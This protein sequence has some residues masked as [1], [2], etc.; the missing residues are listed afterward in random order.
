MFLIRVSA[1]VCVLL[2][3]TAV[4]PGGPVA[5]ETPAPAIRLASSTGVFNLDP[6]RATDRDSLHVIASVYET[7]YQW[8]PGEDFEVKPLLARDMPEFSDDGLTAVIRLRDDA[9]YHANEKVFRDGEPRTANADDVV[10]G[11]TRA[12][13][14]HRTGMG[15]LL[16]GLVQGLDD[17][18]RVRPTIDVHRSEVIGLEAVDEHTVRIRLTRPYR[19]LA[20]LLAHPVCSVVPLEVMD[21]RTG[22]M[23]ARAVGTGPYRL[24]AIAAGELCILTAHENYYGE[25]AAVGRVTISRARYWEEYLAG[26]RQGE[27]AR[28]SIHPNF[29]SEVRDSSGELSASLREA[30]CSMRVAPGHGYYFL[31]F[32]MQ[33]D[34][35][36]AQDDGRALRNA[37]SHSIDRSLITA[38]DK[39][40]AGGSAAQETILPHGAEFTMPDSVGRA[41]G[42]FNRAQANEQLKGTRF[43]GGRNPETGEAL[44]LE[45]MIRGDQWEEPFVQAVREALEAL[46]MELVT[47]TVDSERYMELTRT[48]DSD[49]FISGWF[50]DYPCPLNFLQLFW[51]GN[52]GSSAQFANV[53]RYRSERF[54]RHFSALEALEPTAENRTQR[55]RETSAM[56]RVLTEEKPIV[57]LVR[58][59]ET[60][61]YSGAIKWADMPVQTFNGF[62][63]AQP[64]GTREGE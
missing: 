29:E 11:L 38:S 30:G 31:A 58:I 27:L 63:F 24:H 10:A 3:L 42:A 50:L 5:Q 7:L 55:S 62:R 13:A 33:S 15:W 25:P 54:D 47:R 51:S 6:H 56:V 19:A 20:R 32:N 4:Q 45:L 12:M 53:S 41:Y 36:A 48:S 1:V 16:H 46:G 28:I 23:A 40:A 17:V 60:W 2:L 21:G 35:P 18:A 61:V 34:R 26:I 52:V 64:G 9:V 39:F 49:L 57:P 37:I 44:R 59:P 8:V 22:N 43:E 14:Y